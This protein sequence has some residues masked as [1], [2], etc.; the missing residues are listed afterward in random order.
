MPLR[1]RA[2][3]LASALS[4]LPAIAAA[5][6]IHRFQHGGRATSQA[7][8]FTARAD[9]P[10]AVTYN[11]AGITRLEGFKLQG[12]L[13]FNNATDDY[14]SPGQSHRANH[15]I[16]FPPAVYLTWRPEGPSRFAW[17]LG[18]DEP[19]WY[20]LDW[21]TALFP[22]RSLARTREVR[23]FELHPVVAYELDD[24]WSVG[25]GLRYL[26][27]ELELGANHAGSLTFGPGSG[28][29]AT[30]A[31][32]LENLVSADSEALSFDLGVHYHAVVWGFGAVYR[33]RADLAADGDFD[34]RLRD[35]SDPA[36]SQAVEGAF[37]PGRSRLSFELP[38]EVRLGAWIAPYPELRFEADLALRRWSD[39]DSI[40]VLLVVPVAQPL[41]SLS[42]IRTFP[43]SAGW[44]DTLSLRLGVEGDLDERWSVGAGIAYEPS[45]VPDN[46]DPG[47]PR[48]TATVYSVGGSYHLP[49]ISFDLGYAFF[50]FEGTRA[51][52][53]GYQ[54]PGEVATFSARD[55]V[56][57]ASARW[58]F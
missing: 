38:A 58:R 9:E 57:S 41:G 55:Q 29:P 30:V 19:A 11:P 51:R 4:L 31:F 48:G 20:R 1:P 32:E 13:D 44:D 8:A 16:Q 45:P 26:V 40:D 35:V 49:Q 22:G 21:N 50:D 7:G 6:G 3:L 54:A 5:D 14:A 24:R 34:V 53:Q 36:F 18:L 56:W 33:H 12:G 10:S 27:G 2:A 15:T 43:V 39:L 47:F 25:G 42:E 46:P 23:F 17:G 28:G 52:N 37:R